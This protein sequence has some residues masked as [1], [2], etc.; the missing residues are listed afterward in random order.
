MNKT[1]SFEIRGTIQ[2]REN[3]VLKSAPIRKQC[4]IEVQQGNE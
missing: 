4:T 1:I 3:G 2:W